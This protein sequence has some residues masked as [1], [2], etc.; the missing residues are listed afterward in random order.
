M[1]DTNSKI[2]A[3][4]NTKKPPDRETFPPNQFVRDE[5]GGGEGNQPVHRETNKVGCIYHTG[6]HA[7]KLNTALEAGA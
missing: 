4:I 1:V 3:D 7:I 6:F 5:R 2:N